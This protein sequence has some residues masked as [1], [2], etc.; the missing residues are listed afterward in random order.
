MTIT[1]ANLMNLE[2]FDMPVLALRGLNIF[3]EM[4]IS[5]D[6]QREISINAVDTAM[7]DGQTVFITAQKDASVENPKFDDVY[8]YGVVSVIKQ[9]LKLPNN[10]MR[11]LVEG[12]K[13]GKL[14]AFNSRKPYLSGK[15]ENVEIKSLKR[16]TKKTEAMVRQIMELFE[17]YFSLSNHIQPDAVM[18]V[19]SAMNETDRFSYLVA[20]NINAPVEKR[21]AVLEITG[22]VRRLE[23]LLKLIISE[24]EI[25]RIENE[26]ESKVREKIDK[27]QKE[28]FLREQIKVIQNELGDREDITLEVNEYLAKLKKNNFPEEINE[29]VLKEIKR[30]QLMPTGSHEATVVRTYLD[31]LFDLPWGYKTKEKLDLEK[32]LKVLDREH[33]GL[34]K[35]KERILEYLAVKDEA[36]QK[37]GMILCLIG[38]P[39]V[40]KTSVVSSIA[41]AIGR[42]FVRLSL[43]GVRDEADIRGHRKTY[44]GAMP[45][46]ILNAVKLAGSSNPL[47]LL[48]EIDKMASDFRGD[49][50]A[51]LLEVLDKEQN[52]S[53]RDHYLEI[54]FDLSDVMFITTANSAS[55]IPPALYDRLEII[56]LSSYT[57]LEKFHIAKKHLLPKQLKEHNIIKSKVNISDSAIKEIIN[58]Y[59]MEAGVRNLER[60]LATLVRKGI[61][62]IK[63]NSLE[64]VKITDKEVS[65]YLGARKYINQNDT[66]LNEPGIANGLAYTSY[67]GTMLNIE[68]NV[69]EG[70]GNIELTG[71]LGDVM[72]ESAKAAI[73]YIR[74]KSDK[75]GID[76]EFYNN[77]DIHIHVPE[78]ATPK[79]GPSAGITMATALVSALTGRPVKSDV[80][81]TGEITIRGRVLAI[82]GLK[83]KSLAAHREKI[84]N[85]IIPYDNMKDIEEIPEEIVNDFNFIPVKNMDEVLNYALAD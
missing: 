39:G 17:E 11:V 40:G 5:L 25:L 45:G 44:I 21:Q 18:L 33:Y 13:V 20:S 70:K 82:G 9:V 85:I 10:T 63:K 47:I 19:N 6:V 38:P 52:H 84:H 59:T 67:G 36:P 74:S 81:M 72:K 65:K 31:T 56:E 7:K 77:K 55:T 16:K 71:K 27:N 35:V 46:R 69:L 41:K 50:A 42:K 12:I 22:T 58:F 26:I 53:F 62:E 8:D 51:A 60:E 30:L 54:P 14:L 76:E 29:K 28:Y 2:I 1:E 23:A 15:I 83:E 64:S 34:V 79:D 66:R 24:N 73:C 80:A 78:G 3:P 57:Y 61:F 37:N 43:G 75:L 49:P 68:V 4:I 48:D 32:S